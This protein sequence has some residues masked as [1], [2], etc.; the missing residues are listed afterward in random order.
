MRRKIYD[1]L[2]EWKKLSCGETA[3]IINGARRV[4]KS[5][6]AKYGSSNWSLSV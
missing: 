5:Y 3:V 4:G 1:K 2:L 6:V